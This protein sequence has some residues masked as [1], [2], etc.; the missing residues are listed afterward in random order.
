MNAQPRLLIIGAGPAGVSTAIRL[1]E[2]GFAPLLVERQ[3]FPRD[4]VCGC[5]L[6]MAALSSLAKIQCDR[7]LVDLTEAPLN[8]WE[9]R[10]GKKVISAG[11]PGGIAI[12]RGAMDYALANEAMRRGIEVRMNCEARV[13]N[14][15]SDG[16][17]VS[18]RDAD[19]PPSEVDFDAVVFA[20]GLQ[21][22]GV[23]QWLP[24]VKE[25]SGPVGVGII[26]ERFEGV[27]PRTIHMICGPEGYV[28]LVQLEDG[29]V[30]VAAAIRRQETGDVA[31]NRTRIAERMDAL[32]KRSDLPSFAL[33][34]VERLRMTPPLTRVRVA[35]FGALIVAGDAARYVEPFTGEGMAWAV[36]TGIAAADCIADTWEKKV[37]P[38]AGSAPSSLA[39]IWIPRT[40]SIARRRQWICRAL[41]RALASPSIA[42]CVIPAAKLAPW[43]VKMTIRQLN[44]G[45]N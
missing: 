25:P 5:C 22:G 20:A 43:A 39:D 35:G 44:H 14:V 27:R 28:G 16:V 24:Y 41:S 18:I 17:T 15:R 23:S 26:L 32:L 36:E 29:R 12:S 3:Q 7:L 21:G 19:A 42:K 13:V 34:N 9:M 30:D 6:N 8:Q 45:R 31:L 2:R 40:Q 4:K 33:E 1:R 37:S 10:I 11:L 38:K